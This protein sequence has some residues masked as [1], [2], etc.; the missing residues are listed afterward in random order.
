MIQ[1]KN[2]RS[3]TSHEHSINLLLYRII[4]QTLPGI[5]ILGRISIL[6]FYQYVRMLPVIQSSRILQKAAL[7]HCIELQNRAHHGHRLRVILIYHQLGCAVFLI[8]K[9]IYPAV[10]QCSQSRTPDTRKRKTGFQTGN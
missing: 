2:I 9:R 3:L 6:D 10:L 8:K 1:Y 5:F 7:L 4:V